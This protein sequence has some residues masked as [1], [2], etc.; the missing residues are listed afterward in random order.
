VVLPKP[1]PCTHGSECTR[2][3]G[4][5]APGTR[6]GM[7]PPPYGGFFFFFFSQSVSLALGRPRVTPPDTGTSRGGPGIP[8]T[9]GGENFLE[10]FFPT[11]LE[12]RQAQDPY[13]DPGHPRAAGRWRV[14]GIFFFNARFEALTMA[15]PTPRARAAGKGCLSFF[16]P[17]LKLRFG[18]RT[19][20]PS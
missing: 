19:H 5:R 13:P 1:L 10:I 14:L 11:V 16:E 18:P 12:P 8:E 17:V 20:R 3:R 15:T 9:A 4:T 7:R 6:G 2:V